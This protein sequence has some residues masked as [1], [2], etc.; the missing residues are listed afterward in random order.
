[1]SMSERVRGWL[2]H[3]NSPQYEGPVEGELTKWADEFERL[4][5]R[6]AALLEVAKAGQAYSDALEALPAH[7]RGG[8]VTATDANRLDE[9]F[10]DWQTKNL[11]ALAEKEATP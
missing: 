8:M 5:K 2:R 10:E 4:E 9:L 7:T 11:A 3:C 1:M 6:N